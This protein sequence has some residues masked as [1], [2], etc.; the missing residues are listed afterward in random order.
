MPQY[1]NHTKV[2]NDKLIEIYFIAM[3]IGSIIKGGKMRKLKNSLMI[4]IFCI[5][6]TAALASRILPETVICPVGGEIVSSYRLLSC[7]TYGVTVSLKPI[8]TCGDPI[9]V[10]RCPGNGLPIFSSFTTEE[11][12]KIE[13]VLKVNN[14]KKIPKWMA[15]A[16]IAE[17]LPNHQKRVVEFLIYSFWFETDFF[18]KDGN[19][20]K[21]LVE[22][23]SKNSHKWND[24]QKKKIAI[25]IGYVNLLTRDIQVS[26]KFLDIAS[27]IETKNKFLSDHLQLIKSCSLNWVK[28][29]CE[30]NAR[31]KPQN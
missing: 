10:V 22:E 23:Y 31:I 17:Q 16:L 13:E 5:F 1:F 28:K 18:L 11:I 24:Y 29:Y 14:I 30:P 7:G 4:V 6:S 20:R 19:L 27:K 3:F 2:F 15:A 12:K 8:T 25:I 26:S 9:N 21:K